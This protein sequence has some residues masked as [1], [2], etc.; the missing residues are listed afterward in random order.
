VKQFRS[1]NRYF[2]R[3]DMIPSAVRC[4][5]FD[6]VGTLI[7]A[8]PPVHV[9]YAAAAG[10]FGLILDAATVERRF[11][12]AFRKRYARSTADDN[13]TTSDDIERSRWRGI[14]A[15]VF[16]EVAP[17]EPLFERLWNHFA[18]TASW[19]LFD[20]AA[21]TVRRLRQ[22][23]LSVGVAS[24]FDRRLF[25]ICRAMPP[26]DRCDYYFVSSQLGFR[27]PARDFFH[28]I[29]QATGLMPQELLLAGDDWEADYLAAASAGW[30]AVHL[31]RSSDVAAAVSMRSLV[32]LCRDL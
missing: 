19:R 27:K 28:A 14:V 30:H 4:V 8:D 9:V 32:E 10:E 31:N 7:Y 21:E 26:L 20:D 3:C 16:P 11:G 1:V 24:N 2:L 29:E 5:L 17:C 23:G 12:E 18:Q 15:D 6:A 25:E 22:C 13:Y